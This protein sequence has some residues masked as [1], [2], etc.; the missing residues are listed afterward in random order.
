MNLLRNIPPIHELLNDNKIAAEI[1]QHNISYEE[2]K[3][4]LQDSVQSV[5]DEIRNGEFL[6]SSVEDLFN[7]IIDRTVKQIELHKIHN[8][9]PVINGTGTILHTNLGRARL[10]NQAIDHVV[11][12][13]SYYSTLEYDVTTG[14]RGSR[15]DLV[16][17]YITNLTGAES[18]MVVNNNAAAVYMVLS[19]FAKNY[20][21]I[22]SR[23]ELVEIGGSFRVS[24]I[25]EESGTQL[26]EIGTTNKTHLFDYEQA[27][28][29]DTKMIMKVHTSNFYMSGFTSSVDREELASLAQRH[30][31]I[32]YEDLGSGLLYD[33]SDQGITDEPVVKDV[34]AKGV[35]LVSFSVDKLLGGPQAGIIAGK[36]EYIDAL[37]KH[38]LARVLRVDKMAYAALEETLRLTLTNQVD[39][40]PT[41]RDILKDSSTIRN[42]VMVFLEGTKD[43]APLILEPIEMKSKVGGGTLPEVELDS[44]G[45]KVQC[46]VRTTEELT[47]QLRTCPIPIIVRVENDSVMV[48]F[49]TL[50]RHEQDEIRKAL[51]EL[52]NRLK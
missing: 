11:N 20:E 3:Q 35:D 32:Y 10:A 6:N 24:S 4:S 31:L 16:E 21:A 26:K 7:S 43:L 28:H 51:Q 49:R 17:R 52:N 40:I 47:K 12:S 19:S 46:R 41:L 8:L 5:R 50:E 13:A 14:K 38:Q 44:F 15:H 2:A 1:E 36:K 45:I 33:L 25:M 34:I 29:N 39:Q 22:V 18:A 9:Q 23:G 30:N 37:K 42:E 27:I 48:D